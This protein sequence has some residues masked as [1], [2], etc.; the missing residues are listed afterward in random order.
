[1]YDRRY[2]VNESHRKSYLLMNCVELNINNMP[3]V[4]QTKQA[5]YYFSIFSVMV[6][7]IFLVDTKHQLNYRQNRRNMV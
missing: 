7:L 2:C 6:K 3:P 4:S 5:A 1:M